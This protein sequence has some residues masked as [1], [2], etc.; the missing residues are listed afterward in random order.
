M[1]KKVMIKCSFTLKTRKKTYLSSRRFLVSG[2]GP[3]F[4]VFGGYGLVLQ[5]F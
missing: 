5:G 3:V 1:M 4:C 2:F